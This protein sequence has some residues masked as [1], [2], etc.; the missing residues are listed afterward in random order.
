MYSVGKQG[1]PTCCV[2][3]SDRG[4]TTIWTDVI[5]PDRLVLED[6]AKETCIFRGSCFKSLGV[7]IERVLTLFYCQILYLKNSRRAV[8]Q[9]KTKKTCNGAR[10]LSGSKCDPPFM[11]IYDVG[12][13]IR[14]AKHLG[15]KLKGM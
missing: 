4:S 10:G 15:Y 7:V 9:N 6:E 12:E 3:P 5:E 11:G 14:V 13:C 2:C 1:V 8:C